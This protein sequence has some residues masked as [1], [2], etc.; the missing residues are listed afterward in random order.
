MGYSD[1][2]I[3]EAEQ[4]DKTPHGL[5]MTVS[6][7]VS[8]SG[9]VEVNGRPVTARGDEGT[10]FAAASV[11]MGAHLVNLAVQHAKRRRES[12]A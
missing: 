7:Y 2:S 6:V 12:A 11:I 5:R 3:R 4:I 9:W 10:S 1:K 8:D